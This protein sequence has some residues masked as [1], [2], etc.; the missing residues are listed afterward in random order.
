LIGFVRLHL[1]AHSHVINIAWTPSTNSEGMLNDS[2]CQAQNVKMLEDY[3]VWYFKK[4]AFSNSLWI[5][6]NGI[7]FKKIQDK[8]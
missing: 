5:S 1:R 3:R 4:I 7:F 6:R 2:H 8:R